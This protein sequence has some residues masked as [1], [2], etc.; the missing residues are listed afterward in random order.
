MIRSMG[1]GEQAYRLRLGHPARMEDLVEIFASNPEV[2]PASVGE[3]EEFY[4][5][6]LESLR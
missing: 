5:K 1:S 3:Q 2:V 6:W 4:R